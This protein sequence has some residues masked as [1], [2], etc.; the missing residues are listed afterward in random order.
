MLKVA[1]K[2]RLAEFKKTQK[3]ALASKLMPLHHSLHRFPQS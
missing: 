1:A 3:G 2:V